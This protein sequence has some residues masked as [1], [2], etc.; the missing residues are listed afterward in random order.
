MEK[1]SIIKGVC[2]AAVV[3]A[4]GAYLSGVVGG[5]DVTYRPMKPEGQELSRDDIEYLSVQAPEATS[6]DGTV[7]AADWES[8]YP[9]IVASMG[10]NADNSYAV[11]YLEQDPYL[12]NI[13]EGYGFAK[14]YMSARGHNYC[15]EDVAATARPHGQAKCL[16]CKTPN[17]A[18]MVSDLGVGVYQ[19][20]FE[21]VYAKMEENPSCYSCHGNS[22]GNGGKLEVTHTYVSKCLGENA[23]DIDAAT[24]SCG[25]CHIEYFFYPGTDETTMP[26]SSVAEMTPTA[27]LAYYDSIGFSDWTQEST[28]ASL[29][30]AQHPEME[31][32]LQG[33]HASMLNCA[34]C[35]MEL[36]QADDGTVYHSHKFESPLENENLLKTCVQCHGDKNMTTYVKSIQDE[37]TARETEVGNKLSDFKNSLAAAVAGGTKSEEDLNKVRKLYRDAQWYF[38]FCYVENSEGAHNSSLAKECLNTAEMKI[39]DG[40]ELLV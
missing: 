33:K 13:Y 2:F 5:K 30:K 31:T 3:I 36:I 20:D 4:A 26:Y 28:G 35:H 19:M 21:E 17:F 14:D 7:T 18:K 15:L 6:K 32:Y 11:D 9:Y 24:L 22:P 40:M 37:I 8:T 12:V 23:K 25:Q 34:D 16:T 1:K 10:A 27:I 38:D 29:L 39:R